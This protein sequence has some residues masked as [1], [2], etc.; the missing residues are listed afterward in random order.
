MVIPGK[1]A[2]K[3]NDGCFKQDSVEELLEVSTTTT[4][5]KLRAEIMDGYFHDN[6]VVYML[7]MY[8]YIICGLHA[9]HSEEKHAAYRVYQQYSIG[10]HGS[11]LQYL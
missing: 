3:S 7:S 9:S 11:N 6:K 5:R 8:I 10:F 2:I 1:L 4:S